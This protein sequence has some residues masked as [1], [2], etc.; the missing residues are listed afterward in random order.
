MA[1]PAPTTPPATLDLARHRD[2]TGRTVVAP[3]DRTD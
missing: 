1:D 2:L 3:Q